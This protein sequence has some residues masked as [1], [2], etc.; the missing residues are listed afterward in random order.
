MVL[1]HQ[2]MV[3]WLA[4]ENI[5]AFRSVAD[6]AESWAEKH[7][8]H[9][10]QQAEAQD[11]G[12]SKE[13]REELESEAFLIEEVFHQNF[14]NALFITVY[15]QFEQALRKI[16]EDVK[17]REGIVLS[18][19]D[20]AGQGIVKYQTY[21][22]KVC[23]IKFPDNEQEWSRI[24]NLNTLRNYVVHQSRY[25]D[26]SD[27]AKS[28]RKILKSEDGFLGYD[29][30]IRYSR[31]FINEVIDLFEAFLCEI[32]YRIVPDKKSLGSSAKKRLTYYRRKN[33]RSNM[34]GTAHKKSRGAL[35]IFKNDATL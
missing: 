9:L 10:F 6:W 15:S 22:K 27:L 26:D 12:L 13:D 34:P 23:K 19:N 21:L 33:S 29:Y 18:L 32:C 25:L 5:T 24:R 2:S 7:A 35:P 11:S 16:C 1:I 30:E 3:F 31:T 20:I 8:T 4:I 17:E 14:R 28:I